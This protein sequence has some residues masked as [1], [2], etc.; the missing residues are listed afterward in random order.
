[1]TVTAAVLREQTGVVLN[2][3]Q[4][5]A[6][7]LWAPAALIALGALAGTVPAWVAYRMDVA[8]GLT[9]DA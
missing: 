9:P 2:P 1:M 3:W 5:N 6:V 7:W 8:Q 4:F